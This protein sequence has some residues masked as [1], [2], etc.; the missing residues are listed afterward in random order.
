MYETDTSRVDDVDSSIVQISLDIDGFPSYHYEAPYLIPGFNRLYEVYTPNSSGNH[1]EWKSFSHYKR[2]A[3]LP[4][5]ASMQVYSA[6]RISPSS[7]GMKYSKGYIASALPLYDWQF[8][9]PGQLNSGL[10]SW[11]D[12]AL[13]G[14][15]IPQPVGLNS[16]IQR[17]LTS[18]LPNV[19]PQLSLPN[20]IYELKD[21]KSLPHM[22]RNWKVLGQ[23]LIPAGKKFLASWAGGK[24]T[25]M[26]VVREAANGYLQKKFNI[27][28][29]ISDINAVIKALERTERRLNDFITRQGRK[30]TCHWQC[31]VSEDPALQESTSTTASFESKP[32]GADFGLAGSGVFKRQVV[33]SPAQ[34]HAEIEYNYNY[35]DYQVEHARILGLLDA[36]GVNLN[37]AIVWNA[38]PW[39]F[40]VDWFIGVS[41]WLNDNRL[42]FMDPAINI[43]QFCWSIKRERSIHVE[44]EATFSKDYYG[45]E[46]VGP[47]RTTLPPVR[48]TA[49]R[50]QVGG[51]TASLLTASGLNLQEFTLGAALVISRKRKRK[52][53]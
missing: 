13:T 44:V 53:R 49:Y 24:A 51:V 6:R 38:I 45:N 25:V 40:V 46:F 48:E 15:F 19:R 42:G 41:R 30:R 27:D 43:H 26:D 31:T 52:R 36:L 11:Y 1:H 50:R 20:S 4:A 3:D 12:P 17:A 47:F 7:D 37:P 18:M 2:T 23:R 22:L 39:S 9:P 21:F 16:L 32:L 34:F 14:S 5:M 33:T 8:G 29:L 35:F 10:T 28:P